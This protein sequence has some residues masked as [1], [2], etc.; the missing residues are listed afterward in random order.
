M[1]QEERTE[2]FCSKC[3]YKGTSLW[4]HIRAVHYSKPDPKIHIETEIE[5]LARE[6]NVSRVGKYSQKITR[7][8]SNN[9][10]I[11]EESLK[12]NFVIHAEV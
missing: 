8:I 6:A 9:V 11:S 12:V 2:G 4:K 3:N 10:A 7:Y 1:S 5:G